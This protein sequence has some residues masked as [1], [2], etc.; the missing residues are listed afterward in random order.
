MVSI[1]DID[2]AQMAWGDGIVKIAKAHRDGGDYVGLAENH[3]KTLSDKH[4]HRLYPIKTPEF[5]L[6][7]VP[8][9]PALAPAL[10]E[11]QD[12]YYK[13]FK[14]N[15]VI[16]T[17]SSLLATLRTIDSLWQQEK[18]RENAEA[19]ARQAGALYDKFRGFAEDLITVGKRIDGAQHSYNNAMNKL[20]TGRNN[21]VKQAEKLRKLG[22]NPKKQLPDALLNGEAGED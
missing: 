16:V 6:M 18:R 10:T 3:I 1:E 20:S 9:E 13:A 15:I 2:Q 7:F 5:V 12:L 19:I 21:L 4:Y 14:R 8:L 11:K 17:P 22:A